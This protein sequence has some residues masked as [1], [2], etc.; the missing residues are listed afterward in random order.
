LVERA[1]EFRDSRGLPEEES[2]VLDLWERTLDDIAAGPEKVERRLDWAIKRR[3]L[4][5]Y[6]ERFGLALD[7][8][9]I[10]ALELQYHD[11]NPERGV[12]HRIARAGGVESTFPL[13][14]A[15]IAVAEAP[16][17]TRAHLRGRFIRA[18]KEKGRDFTVDW[19]HLKINDQ[20]QRTVACKDPLRSSDERVDKLIATL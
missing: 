1:R 5:G 12:F 8:P 15:E 9:K 7:A 11:I 3:V 16:V 14:D 4:L 13:G 10:Q 20:A 17:S 19:V 18:A 2:R 6:A